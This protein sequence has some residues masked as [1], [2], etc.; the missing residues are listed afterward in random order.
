MCQTF[1][2]LVSSC[3]SFWVMIKPDEP[4]LF[5]PDIYLN[6]VII[7]VCVHMEREVYSSSNEIR[8]K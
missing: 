8:T 3:S 7:E 5:F 4:R 1:L 2:L 6:F